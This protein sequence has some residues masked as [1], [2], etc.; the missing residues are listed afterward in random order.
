MHGVSLSILYLQFLKT[1]MGLPRDDPYHDC[2]AWI[3]S[4]E[5]F[6]VLL[7]GLGSPRISLQNEGC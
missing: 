5:G 1:A 3:G 7:V 4:G 6:L 2:C